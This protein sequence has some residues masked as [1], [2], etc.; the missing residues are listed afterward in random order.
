M[1]L[2]YSIFNGKSPRQ[3]A[4][5]QRILNSTISVT[6]YNT[7]ILSQSSVTKSKSVAAYS[8]RASSHKSQTF[9]PTW[10]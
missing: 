6:L 3:E 8:S 9:N 2:R 1:Q 10:N 7:D 5:A 4:R